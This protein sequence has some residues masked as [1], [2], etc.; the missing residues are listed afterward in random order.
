[1]NIPIYISYT[2]IYYTYIISTYIIQSIFWVAGMLQI[3]WR[4][5]FKVWRGI[6]ENSELL[7]HDNVIKWKHFSALLALCAGNSPVTGELPWERPV[8]RSFYVSF[9]VRL[10]KVLSKQ[11]RRRWFETPLRSLWRHCNDI[12]I[13]YISSN[14]ANMLPY[15]N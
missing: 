4:Y 14:V 13:S 1:M 8:T 7:H 11:S 3:C 12:S 5:C 6:H 2:Y 10:N 9:G 15:S